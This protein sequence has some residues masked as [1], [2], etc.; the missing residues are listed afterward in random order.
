MDKIITKNNIQIA[1]L[2]AFLAFPQA[3]VFASLAGIPIVYGIIASILGT[4]I[5]Q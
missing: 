1:L 2:S 5:Y 3:I 4:L